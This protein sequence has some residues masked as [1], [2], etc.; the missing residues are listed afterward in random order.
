M[1]VE[2]KK[3][4]SND[5]PNIGHYMQASGNKCLRRYSKK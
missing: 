1:G 2:T 3:R 4:K 5:F